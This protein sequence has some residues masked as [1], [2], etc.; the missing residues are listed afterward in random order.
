MNLSLFI[1]ALSWMVGGCASEPR[2][3]LQITY[4]GATPTAQVTVDWTNIVRVSRSTPTL[5][6]VVN[7]PLRRGTQIHDPV[8]KELHHLGA[9]EVRY[10]PWLPYPK[11]AV[12]ELQPPTATNTFWD[13]RLIDPMTLDFLDATK[14]HSPILNFSTMPAWLFKTPQ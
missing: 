3:W 8:F 12:A 11:L 4:T 13:F 6:V 10:V 14:G 7:P 1:L 9:Q 5:Q 2:N